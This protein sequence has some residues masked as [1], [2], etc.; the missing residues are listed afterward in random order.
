[1]GDSGLTILE[2]KDSGDVRGS[3]FPVPADWFSN[4]FPVRDVHITTVLPGHIR[5]NHYHVVRHEVLIV[6]FTDQWSLHWDNGAETTISRRRFDGNGAVV[7]RVP[8]HSSHAIRNDGSA[9]LHLV[10]LT[11]GAYDPAAPDAFPRE[12]APP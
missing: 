4:T 10:G 5:G 2:L 9:L 11:D 7:I 12:V 3:S 1:M 6:I 8:P